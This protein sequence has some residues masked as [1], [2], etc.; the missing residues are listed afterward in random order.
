MLVIILGEFLPAEVALVIA[1]TQR[2]WFTIVE[3]IN[4]IISFAIPA[5]VKKE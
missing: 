3:G 5:K 2:I 1:V 4:I